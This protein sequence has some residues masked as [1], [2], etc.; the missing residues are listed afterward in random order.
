MASYALLLGTNGDKRTLIDSG[1]PVEIRRKFKEVDSGC[2]FELVEVLDKHLGRVRQRR[3]T[4][5]V[6]KIAAKKA[7]KKA[8]N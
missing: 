8:T 1:Q 3:F 5:P 6:A 7:A 2:G 4:K